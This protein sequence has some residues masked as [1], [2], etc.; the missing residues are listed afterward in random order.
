[1]SPSLRVWVATLAG[2]VLAVAAFAAACPAAAIARGPGT[3]AATKP[4]AWRAVRVPSAVVSP[5]ELSDVSATGPA[6]AWA[7]GA[8]A[9]TG[10]ER[11]RPL[12]LHWNGRAWSKVTL[13]GVPGPG[14]LSSVSAG[15]RSDVW[16]LGTDR[17]GAVLLHWNGRRWRAVGFPGRATTAMT[18]VAAAPGGRA[19][20]AGSR[21]DAAGNSEILVER[22]NGVAWHIVATRLGQGMFN[23][24]RVSANGDVWAVGASPG[25]SSLIAHEHRGAWTSFPG[26]TSIELSDL[27]ARSAR[28]VWTGGFQSAGPLLQPVISHW[29]G[30][31]WTSVIVPTDVFGGVQSIS[32]DRAGLPQWAGTDSG[33]NGPNTLYDFF[34]GR[35]WSSVR[36]A[37]T[38]R[39][40]FDAD[41]VTA[42]IPFT[43]ATWGV[44]GSVVDHGQGIQPF[45]AIIE[46]NPG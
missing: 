17:L 9:E 1:M 18:T 11:G 34:N 3:T 28:D 13:R 45:R 19:W 16:A 22:W 31:T 44:G 39:G 26:P 37:T 36:G 23:K 5:A 43:N 6:D 20:L 12:I 4:P 46:F 24:V 14:F 40:I 29:N 42:H 15:S 10:L 8:D 27:L 38:L 21:T 33:V 30:R 25:S 7:V 35:A 41:T 32:P 2:A